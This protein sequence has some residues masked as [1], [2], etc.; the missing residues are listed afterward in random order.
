MKI[1]NYFF[2]ILFIFLVTCK[3]TVP[4]KYPQFP[5]DLEGSKLRQVLKNKKKIAVVVRDVSSDIKNNLIKY[6]IYNEWQETVRAAM[7]TTLEEY[8]YYIVVD[9]DSRSQR[10][11]E[12][13][14]SQTGITKNQKALGQELNIDHLFYVSMTAAP[15]VECKTEM[16]T[17]YKQVTT[18]VKTKDGIVEKTEMVPTK[19]IQRI[20]FL[21]I[22]LEATLVNIETGRSIS[23]SNQEP[24]TF[25]GTIGNPDCPS[26]LVAFNHAINAAVKKIADKLS[27]KVITISVPLEDKEKSI[28]TENKKLV[29]QLLE[30]GVKWMESGNVEE[31]IN[32]WQQALEESG[33]T[34]K[35]AY[36]N[37]AVAMWYQGELE[38]AQKY[39]DQAMK[40]GGSDFFDSSKR[41]IYT[42]FKQEKKR[43]E[44]EED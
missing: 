41:K 33:G 23:S 3:T 42:I 40:L 30:N 17:T 1:Y 35:S 32:S 8:G 22:F 37:I 43:I 12:L 39:F 13:A 36:W 11:N 31:A 2:K 44:E 10:Y 20:L 4:I 14:R 18:R 27:P 26:E 6:Q 34:S 24:Y 5:E 7:K 19:E 29:N 25:A 15:R 16:V 9:I 38:K 21:T 28:S